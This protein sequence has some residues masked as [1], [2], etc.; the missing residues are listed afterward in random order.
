MT[1][2]FA[3][4]VALAA[5]NVALPLS[6]ASAQTPEQIAAPNET[7]VARV[8]AEGAQVYECKPNSSGQLAW[9]F[10]EPVAT[11]LDG[12]KTVGRHYAGP[13]WELADG[14]VIAARV[15]GRAPAA[16]PQDI[17]LLKLEVTSRRGSGQLA[18]VTTVQR[19]NTKGGVAEG[20]CSAAGAFLNVPYA[21]DYVFLKK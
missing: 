20:P 3:S 18:D 5:I 1:K 14:S 9:Q 2:C 17:P 21:A 15:S 13:H 7:V 8:H 6:A 10:R 19:I 11:L 12:D 4:I 16:T